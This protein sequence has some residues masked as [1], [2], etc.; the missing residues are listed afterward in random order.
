MLIDVFPILPT[1]LSLKSVKQRHH[2]PKLSLWTS[3]NGRE[4]ETEH[5]RGREKGRLKEGRGEPNKKGV[6][7]LT[8]VSTCTKI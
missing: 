5:E 6:I 7:I 3:R 4:E 8:F 1:G 2:V